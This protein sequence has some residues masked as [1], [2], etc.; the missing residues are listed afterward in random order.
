LVTPGNSGLQ[1]ALTTTL[2]S[3]GLELIVHQPDFLDSQ[4]Y[5]T[6]TEQ[7]VVDLVVF[8][9][10]TPGVM[11]MAN[12]MFWGAKPPGEWQVAA[13]NP[14]IFVLYSNTTHPVTLNLNLD[15]LAFL[16][17]SAV[18]G[19][20]ASVDLLTANEGALM[21]IGPRDAFQD[22]VVGFSL[23]DEVDGQVSPITDWPGRISFPVFVYNTLE[24]LGRLGQKEIASSVRPGQMIRFRLESE[25]SELTVVSPAGATQRLNRL[26]DGGYV[27]TGTDKLGVYRVRTAADQH[28]RSFAVSLAD[29]RESDI[30]VK[31]QTQVGDSEVV[32]STESNIR[33]DSRLWRYILLLALFVLF[34]EWIVYN[35]RIL[36]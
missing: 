6:L 36:L 20:P 27:F 3:E 34:L 14:P 28:V 32:A 15:T 4:A 7:P 23:V 5:Q 8:D 17:A 19:P 33:G 22:L 21:V 11:P 16:R 25:E 35:R 31:P 12:T 18:Q 10:V 2:I 13:L 9:R 30:A 24:F 26:S 29:R 1:A